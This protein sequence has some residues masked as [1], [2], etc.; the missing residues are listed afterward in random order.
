[1]DGWMDGWMDAVEV[2]Y[3]AKRVAVEEGVD[4]FYR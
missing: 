3:R 4:V 1:M 2:N